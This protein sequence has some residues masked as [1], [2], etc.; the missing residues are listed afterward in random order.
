MATTAAAPPLMECF[1]TLPDPRKQINQEHK[2]IDIMVIGLCAVICGAEGYTGMEAF[3]KAK[4]DWLSTFLELPNGIPS[5]DTFGAVF[6]RL[7]PSAFRDC[8]LGWVQGVACQLPGE[9]VPIDGKH[10]RR[11][12]DRS[13]G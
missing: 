8:F 12:H 13:N 11:S 3:G 1:S 5:H 7:K 10:L 2:F 4:K 6:G 9:I